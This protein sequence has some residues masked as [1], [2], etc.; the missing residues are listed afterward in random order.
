MLIALLY[1][2]LY[3]LVFGIFVYAVRVFAYPLIDARFQML[4]N[5]LLVVVF[6]I[7]VVSVIMPMFIGGVPR[8]L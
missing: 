2:I 1:A 6:L 7:F 8:F 4:V 3:I 5:L